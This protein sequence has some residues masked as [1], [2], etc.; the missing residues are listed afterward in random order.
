MPQIIGVGG[1]EVMIRD[2]D[3]N[4]YPISIMLLFVVVFCSCAITALA[5]TW[6]HGENL[7]NHAVSGKVLECQGRRYR[8]KFA[9]DDK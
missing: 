5:V 8:I 4:V 1:R 2:R 9:E 6:I 7:R 3:N